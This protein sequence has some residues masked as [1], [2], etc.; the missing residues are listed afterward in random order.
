VYPSE[1][2]PLAK[3]RVELLSGN[4][5]QI[6]RFTPRLERWSE[7][8]H[9][10]VPMKTNKR[11]DLVRDD[12]NG[13]PFF[14]VE[15]EP[16]FA[17]L[18]ILRK[19]QRAGW[20]GVWVDTFKGKYRTDWP[21][22]A[23]EIDALP[24]APDEPGELPTPGSPA[25]RIDLFDFC[26]RKMME[27]R[28]ERYHRSGCPDIFVWKDDHYFFVESKNG[29]KNED[30]TRPQKQWMEAILEVGVSPEGLA[31]IVSVAEWLPGTPQSHSD[32]DMS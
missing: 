22:P 10:P 31:G 25:E 11:G 24:G 28:G 21:P 6:T 9:G 1:L 17:E 18:A 15:G 30:F 27:Q 2:G 23:G 19:F 13:K 29:M 12:Y 26:Y 8:L 14:W 3:K 16:K 20:E 4:H 32:R 5:V 7:R